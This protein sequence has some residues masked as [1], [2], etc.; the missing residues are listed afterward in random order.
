MKQRYIT[1]G[2]LIVLL[3]VLM[4][5]G[6]AVLSVAAFICICFAVYEEYHALAL[7]GHNV[8]LV[9]CDLRKPAMNRFFGGVYSSEMP[10]NRMLGRPYSRENLLQ[11]MVRNEQLGLYMLFPQGS[12]SRSTELVSSETMDQLIRQLRVFDYVIID[13]PPM[14]MFPDAEVLADKSDASLM[15]VRQDYT[16]ACDVNDAIDSL[17]QY[18][19]SFLGVV[20][21]DMLVGPNGQYGYGTKYGR[22]S[23][24]GYAGKYSYNS[25]SSEQKDKATK[26]KGKEK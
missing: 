18:H 23:R 9:D 15:V 5:F 25:R 1:A 4:Y 14:G 11:C 2:L 20:L 12:D 21:N 6:G 22:G 3:S 26:T 13:S 24:Y 10:L 16:A 7:K 8:A 17:R 19:A